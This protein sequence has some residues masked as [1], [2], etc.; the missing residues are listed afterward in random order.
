MSPFYPKLSFATDP[1]S[2]LLRFH[3]TIRNANAADYYHGHF[4]AGCRSPT[5]LMIINLL[6]MS[7]A[8]AIVTFDVRVYIII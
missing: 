4:S 8:F 3:E 1:H 6:M 2:Q 5:R 7:A